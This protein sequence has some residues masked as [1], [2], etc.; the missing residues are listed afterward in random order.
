MDVNTLILTFLVIFMLHNL[1]EIIM[2]ERWG[3]VNYP[4]VKDKIPFFIQKELESFIHVT[5]AQF[6]LIVFI[7]SVFSSILL[8]V[9]VIGDYMFLFLGIAMVFAIN[10]F[11]H[12]IQSLLLRTYTPGVF[13]S[14]FLVIPYYIILINYFRVEY[15][16]DMKMVFGALVVA[17]VFILVLILSHMIGEKVA[18]KL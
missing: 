2:V 10:I 12:P 5:A 8:L 13:T 4:Q 7:I 1:E 15:F 9:A 14:I 3:K 11:S 16:V 18:K 17:A 6:A